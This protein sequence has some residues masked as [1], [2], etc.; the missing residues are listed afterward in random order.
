MEVRRDEET[1]HYSQADVRDADGRGELPQD[2]QANNPGREQPPSQ[3]VDH[4]GVNLREEPQGQASEVEHGALVQ[5][6]FLSASANQKDAQVI[7]CTT[8]SDHG[9]AQQSQRGRPNAKP[10]KHLAAVEEKR[11]GQ[12]DGNLWADEGQRET[13]AGHTII[14][15]Q[16][17]A[18]PYDFT[19]Q[20]KRGILAFQDAGKQRLEEQHANEEKPYL[21]PRPVL[22]A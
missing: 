4:T 8:Q 18:Q 5:A 19:E 2:G 15:I 14:I 7:L 16:Q 10:P 17:A 9:Q 12:Q 11:D 1:G 22:R 13:Q 21:R 20:V 6:V 3:P